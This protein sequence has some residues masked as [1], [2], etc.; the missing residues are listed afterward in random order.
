MRLLKFLTLLFVLLEVAAWCEPVLLPA[1]PFTLNDKIS[2]CQVNH[3]GRVVLRYDVRALGGVAMKLQLFPGKGKDRD[4]VA[5]EFVF[6]G[7]SGTSKLD[8]KGLP[9]LVYRVLGTPLDAQG[10]PLA[11]GEQAV[12]LCW[13]G[14]RAWR[15]YDNP[16]SYQEGSGQPRPPFHGLGKVKADNQPSLELDPPGIVLNRGQ[17]QVVEAVLRNVGLQEELEWSMEGDGTFRVINNRRIYYKADKGAK[18]GKNATIRV[19]CR[20]RP[21]LSASLTVIVTSVNSGQIER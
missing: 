15:A 2:M 19:A 18:I 14:G 17:S 16:T 6:A 20:N 12:M 10:Q 4:K 3:G 8:M 9:I 5:R 1:P 7:P 13:G 11:G 21:E